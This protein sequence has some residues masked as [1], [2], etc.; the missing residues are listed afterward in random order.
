LFSEVEKFALL[1]HLRKVAKN[2]LMHCDSYMGMWP[3]NKQN[4]ALA[5][6]QQLHIEKEIHFD[7]DNIIQTNPKA[8]NA[9]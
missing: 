6:L 8:A 5:I 1:T 3:F 4:K 7:R 2:G 9:I